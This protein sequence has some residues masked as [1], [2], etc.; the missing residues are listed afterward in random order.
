MRA[1]YDQVDVTG[2]NLAITA[3]AQLQMLFDGAGSTVNWA[4]PFWASNRS[5]T[6]IEFT[7]PGSSTGNFSLAG[8]P[9]T[10]LDSASQSL[11]SQRQYASFEVVNSANSVLVNY[12]VPEPSTYALAGVGGGLAALASLRRRNRRRPARG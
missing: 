8:S 6:V 2:G 5:W 9:T 4:D 7:S 11:Q 10:W 3:G 1:S 12:A